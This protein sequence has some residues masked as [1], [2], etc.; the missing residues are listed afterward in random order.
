[1]YSKS[2]TVPVGAF[3]LI[4]APSINETSLFFLWVF[5]PMFNQAVPPP[6]LQT[7]KQA[8]SQ[9]TDTMPD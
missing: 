8:S 4:A 6:Y 1:M 9:A 5:F 3:R 2:L 7:P